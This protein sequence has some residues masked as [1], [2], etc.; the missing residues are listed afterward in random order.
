MCY[1]EINNYTCGCE[2][3]GEKQTCSAK[4][5]DKE[6]ACIGP[7]QK[8]LFL[9][10]PCKRCTFKQRLEDKIW[11]F[12][13]RR[14]GSTRKSKDKRHNIGAQQGAAESGEGNPKGPRVG[15]PRE[16]TLVDIISASKEQTI[17]S[18][19]DNDNAAAV[20]AN[21]SDFEATKSAVIN[22]SERVAW[23]KRRDR[24]R[25]S[26][27]TSIDIGDYAAKKGYETAGNVS[28]D[29]GQS[30]S[31]ASANTEESATDK[32]P[33]GAMEGEKDKE[34]GSM[35]KIPFASNFTEHIGDQG[36]EA[37][38]NTKFVHDEESHKDESAFLA[39]VDTTNAEEKDIG[40]NLDNRIQAAAL[41]A[42]ISDVQIATKPTKLVGKA[43]T[44]AR[45][46][47]GGIFHCFIVHTRRVRAAFRKLNER[48]SIHDVGKETGESVINEDPAYE[49]ASP[50]VATRPEVTTN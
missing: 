8:T 24:N 4:M 11:A 35:S 7:S 41:P 2:K 44:C 9:P 33:D 38:E 40:A 36:E 16:D 37:G 21:S 27:A 28:K 6:R 42:V 49:V 19:A 26:W 46:V 50:E 10:Y 23:K 39:G 31:Q 12:Q 1:R 14:N 29:S 22:N 20:Q 45:A 30:S 3:K 5:R 13:N 15:L 43:R 47:L 25:F 34:S 18:K 17:L 32:S 48:G